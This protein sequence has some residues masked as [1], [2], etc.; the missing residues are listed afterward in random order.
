MQ[1]RFKCL[2]LHFPNKFKEKAYFKLIDVY[3]GYDLPFTM[4]FEAVKMVSDYIFFNDSNLENISCLKIV[5]QDEMLPN[6]NYP[7]DH[8]FLS[9]DFKF[10][11]NK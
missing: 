3:S 7:S 9:C 6:Q 8:M 1:K 11:Q 10:K 5:D 2:F 4:F